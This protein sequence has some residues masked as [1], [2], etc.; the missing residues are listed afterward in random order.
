M[1]NNPNLYE[2]LKVTFILSI[3]FFI[4]LKLF[5]LFLYY[6]PLYYQSLIL[7]NVSLELREFPGNIECDGCCYSDHNTGSDP[8]P[9]ARGEQTSHQSHLWSCP[10][11]NSGH[12]VTL[13]LTSWLLYYSHSLPCLLWSLSTCLSL[14]SLWLEKWLAAASSLSLCAPLLLLCPGS[15]RPGLTQHDWTEELRSATAEMMVSGMNW[16]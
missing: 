9:H 8:P 5:T 13:S 16:V 15:A 7:S 3:D 10:S 2:S 6:I 12:T 1:I 11:H 14:D 4:Y